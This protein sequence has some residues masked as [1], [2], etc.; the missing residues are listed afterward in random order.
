MRRIRRVAAAVA[1]VG[2]VSGCSVYDDLTTSDF[3]K[4]DADAIAAAAGEAMREVTSMRLTGPVRA[5][6]NQFFVDL[7]VDREARCTGTFRFGSSHVDVRRAGDRVWVKGEPGVYNR[8]GSTRLPAHALRRLSTSWILL[9][10]DK[11]LQRACDLDT[12]LAEFAVVDLAS[13]DDVDDGKPE[14]GAGRAGKGDDLAGDVPATVGEET[15]LGEQKVV[16]LSGRPGGTHE[17]IVWVRSEAPHYVVRMESTSAQ[18]GG[19]LAL[20]E[21]NEDVEVEEPDSKDVLRL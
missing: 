2:A 5:G 21:F 15:T 16:P 11:D 9:E 18:D 8:L 20:S 6:G 10:D 19:S 1:L 13:D 17:E 3:A 4:Q 7:T 14:K 12:L